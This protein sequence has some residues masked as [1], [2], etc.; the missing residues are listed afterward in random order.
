MCLKPY[1]ISQEISQNVVIINAKVNVDSE[2]FN[3][4]NKLNIREE[5]YF[6]V[7][8]LGIDDGSLQM[9]FG[10]NLWSEKRWEH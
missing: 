7:K 5:R 10:R 3:I 9:R 2:Q 1:E 4:I 8:R 6:N